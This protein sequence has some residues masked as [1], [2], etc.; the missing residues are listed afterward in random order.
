VIVCDT[1]VLIS[2]FAFPGGLPDRIFRAILSGRL[3]HATSPD[4]LTE[5]SRVLT[6]KLML[7]AQRVTEV[8]DVVVESSTLVY[9]SRRLRIITNDEADNRVL[10]CAE[11]ASAEFIVSGDR[12]HVLPLGRHGSALIVSPRDFATAVGIV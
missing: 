3:R 6:D 12:R 1:N 2:A 5:L 11:A 7:P 4:I 10:E 9:P 8:R